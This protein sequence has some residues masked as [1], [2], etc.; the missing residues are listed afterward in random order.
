MC[1][2][3][4][5]GKLAEKRNQLRYAGMAIQ[6]FIVDPPDESAFPDKTSL[7]DDYVKFVKKAMK[8]FLN[9][10]QVARIKNSFPFFAIM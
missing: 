6:F 2:D 8:F 5:V 9:R 1:K 7:S 4:T 3:D 10:N